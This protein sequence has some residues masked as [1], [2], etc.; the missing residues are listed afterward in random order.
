MR[1]SGRF[2][3][4]VRRLQRPRVVASVRAAMRW[5][6]SEHVGMRFEAKLRLDPCSF[7]HPGEAR[8]CERRSPF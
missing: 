7:E 4:E 6:M 8:A 2:V 1:K 3:T 5:R